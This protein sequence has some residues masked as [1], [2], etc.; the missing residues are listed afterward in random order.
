MAAKKQRTRRFKLRFYLIL[1]VP[2]LLVGAYVGYRILKPTTGR[3]GTDTVTGE[4][5]F[6]G[7]IIRRE[8]VATSEDYHTIRYLV[9]EGNLVSDNQQVA[10]LYRKGFEN[11]MS[12]IV[13]K[14]QQIYQQQITLLRLTSSDGMTVPEEVTSYNAQIDDVVNDMTKASL[15]KKGMEDYIELA[16]KLDGLLTDRQ[17]LLRRLVPADN[18][19]TLAASYQQLDNLHKAFST[20]S[21]LVN[22][23][24]KGYISFHL[25]GYENAMSIDSLTASQISRVVSSNGV[26]ASY[27]AAGVYRI[28]DPNG[29]YVAFT[30]KSEDSHRLIVGNTYELKVKYQDTVYTGRVVAERPAAKNVLYILEVNRDVLPVLENRT[31]TFSIRSEA[32]GVS[33]PVKGLYFN[34]GV[35]YVFINTGRTYQPIQVVISASD[36]ETAIIEAADKNIHLTRGLRF[37]YQEKSSSDSS[38]TPTPSYTAAPTPVPTP[39]PR[40]TPVP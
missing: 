29:F 11:Q 1:M 24:G 14:E 13:S 40:P 5:E 31:M 21:V 3:L 4:L 37:Q 33:I 39:T 26:S 8:N 17:N 20:E 23:A 30:V 12:D 15:G 10:Y 35:P 18:D 36:G 28:V 9:S 27:N 2:I 16:E 32:S 25:D 6:T 34:G 7:V 38:A 19:A 22:N